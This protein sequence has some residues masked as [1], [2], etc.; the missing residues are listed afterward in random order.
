MRLDM[1]SKN[2]TVDLFRKRS[3]IHLR[4]LRLEYGDMA[5]AARMIHR[6]ISGI[7][8][9]KSYPRLRGAAVASA[10]LLNL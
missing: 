1:S 4:H 7:D 2:I 5:H 3:Q 8:A 9:V 6:T 10:K